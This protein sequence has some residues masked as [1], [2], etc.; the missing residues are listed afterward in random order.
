MR[1]I[2][3]LRSGNDWKCHVRVQGVQIYSNLIT[4]KV[5]SI[6]FRRTLNLNA[7]WKLRLKIHQQRVP[8][9]L[10]FV[11]KWILLKF[12]AVPEL[13]YEFLFWHFDFIRRYSAKIYTFW[14]FPYK[15]LSFINIL[16]GMIFY[17]YIKTTALYQAGNTNHSK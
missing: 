13:L 3:L 9:P 1:R 15:S 7:L 17:G 5:S 12:I 11:T 14:T 10:N 2:K 6:E 8:F 16:Y 4:S